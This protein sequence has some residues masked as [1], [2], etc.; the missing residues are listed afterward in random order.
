M[1]ESI[2]DL[3]ELLRATGFVRY[4]LV[5]HKSNR[6]VEIFVGGGRKIRKILQTIVSCE[7]REGEK[8]EVKG[9][10]IWRCWFE[11]S[12]IEFME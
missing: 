3:H 10:P 7:T 11:R 4:R 9:L 5:I 1:I 12:Q 6:H 8:W 2:G